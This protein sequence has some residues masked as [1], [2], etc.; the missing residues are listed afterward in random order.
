M[1][2]SQTGVWASEVDIVIAEMSWWSEEWSPDTTYSNGE[3]CRNV[4][5]FVD[6]NRPGSLHS[7]AQSKSSY[8][9]ILEVWDQKIKSN[10]TFFDM[11]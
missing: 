6:C 5:S 9:K 11:I 10:V 8:L 3:S 2:V 4:T 1:A 7:T